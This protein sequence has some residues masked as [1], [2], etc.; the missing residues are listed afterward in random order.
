M[1]LRLGFFV[2]L[3]PVFNDVVVMDIFNS[4]YIH[5]T[6]SHSSQKFNLTKLSGLHVPYD[7][8]RD[9]GENDED[10]SAVTLTRE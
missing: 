7:T 10:G 1:I 5:N 6:S 3:C 2:V 8:C 9:D 4:P